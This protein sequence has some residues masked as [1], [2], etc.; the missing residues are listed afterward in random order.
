[1][2]IWKV[3][4]AASMLNDLVCQFKGNTVTW[5]IHPHK[6]PSLQLSLFLPFFGLDCLPQPLLWLRISGLHEPKSAAG[7]AQS[8][9]PV[10]QLDILTPV[11][12]FLFLCAFSAGA[13]GAARPFTPA[14]RGLGLLH[15]LSTS[16]SSVLFSRRCW[17]CAALDP[18]CARP[19]LAAPVE[20]FFFL[21]AFLAGAAGAAQPFTPAVR[22]LGLLHRAVD[23]SIRRQLEPTWQ[24]VG[25]RARQIVK[26]YEKKAWAFPA[27]ACCFPAYCAIQI[28][29][30]LLM[31]RTL[32]AGSEN[33][34]YPCKLPHSV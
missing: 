33:A 8:F 29:R 4:R 2:S 26:G 23:E 22:G 5:S 24:T 18:C 6:H 14:V 16:F 32:Y 12:H 10:M 13:A 20:H 3:G 9:T 21:C 31:L 11:E 30:L 1:M 17:G 25:W 27:F 19:W 7:D 34:A 15:Q 28:E